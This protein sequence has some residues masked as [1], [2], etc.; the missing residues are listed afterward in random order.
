VNRSSRSSGDRWVVAKICLPWVFGYV[1]VSN[2]K[3][4]NFQLVRNY[5]VTY[6]TC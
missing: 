4:I 5:A 1:G 2:H 3:T 6:W